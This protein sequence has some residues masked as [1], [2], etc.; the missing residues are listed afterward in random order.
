M[1]VEF[2]VST[3][4]DDPE[5]RVITTHFDEGASYIWVYSPCSTMNQT[6]PEAKGLDFDAGLRAHVR[7][8]QD[9]KGRHRV[10]LAGDLNV[11]PMEHDS[12]VPMA[13]R[14]SYP[15]TKEYEI[16]G[17]SDLLRE[18]NFINATERFSPHPAKTWRKKGY[19]HAM[20]ID[21]VLAPDCSSTD[22][23]TD[24]YRAVVTTYKVTTSLYNSDHHAA[25]FTVASHSNPKTATTPPGAAPAAV[26][27]PFSPRRQLQGIIKQ[28]TKACKDDYIRSRRVVE[29]D[30]ATHWLDVTGMELD[31]S[32]PERRRDR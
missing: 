9:E 17:Y 8:V 15:S 14:P 4:G 23:N 5:G 27:A 24:P 31:E 19:G 30:W 13:A 16:Q 10:V 32:E 2:G 3:K 7:R 29:D 28:I 11:A 25:I 12:N 1:T 18:G 22:G 21:H 20:R 26:A 6:E